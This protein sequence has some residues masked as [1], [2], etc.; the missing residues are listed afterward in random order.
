M[1][2]TELA[3]AQDSLLRITRK[4]SKST[5]EN[6]AKHAF[7]QKAINGIT[8]LDIRRFLNDCKLKPVGERNMLRN[9]SVFIYLGRESTPH[10]GEPVSWHGGRRAASC[11]MRIYFDE[12][13]SPHLVAG[14]RAIHDGRRSEDVTVASWRMNFA[15]GPRT[16]AEVLL[17]CGANSSSLPSLEVPEIRPLKTVE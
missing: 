16:K 7:K 12:N 2:K 3:P 8:K 15:A 5:L 17:N 11:R 13:F 6:I 9:L 4:K 14:I 1:K 10:A